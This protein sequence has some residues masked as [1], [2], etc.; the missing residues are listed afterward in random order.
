MASQLGSIGYFDNF[1]KGIFYN[2]I[3]KTRRNIGNLS[4]LFLSLLYLGVHKYGTACSK[5]NGMLRKKCRFCE[6]LHTVIQ[7]F[8][9]GFDKGTAAGGACFI[10]LYAVN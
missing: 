1:V 5:I 9:K 4:S 3:S 6:I 8:G 7:G 10:E 2:G